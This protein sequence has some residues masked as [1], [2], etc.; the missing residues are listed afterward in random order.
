MRLN[1]Y[2]LEAINQI[3]PNSRADWKVMVDFVYGQNKDIVCKGGVMHAFWHDGKWNC[4]EYDLMTIID[5]DISKK[6]DDIKNTHPEAVVKGMYMNSNKTKVMKE[7]REYTKLSPQS[8]ILFNRRILFANDKMKKSDY[9]TTQLSYSPTPG[10]CPAFDELSNV[11]YSPEELEKILWFMGALLTNNMLKIQKFLYLYG[12]KGTGKGTMISIFK[13]LFED[14]WAP[15]DLGDLT[16][17][18]P[19][20]TGEIKEVPLLIDDDTDISNIKKDT[21]LLKLTAHE[22]IIINSKYKQTYSMRFEGLLITASNQRFKVRN[23]DSGITR[24]AVVAS[25]SNEKIHYKRYN[26]LMELIKYELPQIAQ[27]AMDVFTSN[28]PAYYEEYVDYEMIEATDYFY[29]F[30]RE[31]A[32]GLGDPCTLKKASELYKVYVDDMGYESTGYKRKVK[33]ELKRYYTNFHDAKKVGGQVLKNIFEGFKW[34]IVFPEKEGNVKREVTEEELLKKHDIYDQDSIFD[35]TAA[36]YPAQEATKEETPKYKWENVTT[37]LSQINTRELHYVRVPQN[38][39]VIDF[40][41]KVDNEK[42]LLKNLKA[43]SKYPPTYTELS[44]SGKGIH[45]HYIYEGDETKLAD[46]IDDN[47]EIKVY[48]GKSSLRRKLTKC[49]GLSIAHISSGLPLKE[50][51]ADV[52]KDIEILQLNEK[53]MRALVKGNLERKYHKNTKPSIDFIVKTFDD[54]LKKGVQYDLRD[55]RQDVLNFAMSSSNQ[56]QACLKLV[57]QIVFSTIE[58]EDSVL[59]QKTTKVIPNE[60]LYFY[61]LEVYPNLFICCYKRYGVDK[62]ERLINPKPEELEPIIGRPLVGYNNRRYDNH[63]MYGASIGEDNLSLYRQS[64]RI[65]NKDGGNGFYGGA[66]ELSYTDIYDYCNAANKKSLKKWEL[67]LGIKHDE[68][69]FPW[70]QPVPEEY[71]ERVA[72]YCANDVMATEA[73]FDATQSDYRTRQISS[74]LSGLSMNATTNQHTTKIIFGGDKNPEKELVYTDLGEIFPG[75][76][77]EFGKSTYRG[78][79]PGEGGYVYAEPGVYL[80]VRIY[81][82]TSQHPHSLI[83]LNALG[84]YTKVFEDLVNARV[85]I[86]HKQFE[87]AAKLF[88]GKLKPFLVD[89][90]TASDLANGL[91]TAI[92]SV[93]GL[94]SAK[95]PN[96]FKHP[97]NND[98]IVAKRGA[99]FMIDLKHAIMDMGYTV[100]HIKTDSIKIPNFPSGKEGED[101]DKFIMSFAE[102]YKYKFEHEATYDKLALVNKS[103]YICHDPNPRKGDPEWS[104]TGAQ[105]KEPYVFKTLFSKEEIEKEDFFLAKEVKDAAIY[106]GDRFVGKFA[107]VYASKSGEEMFRVVDDKKSYLNGTKG[108]LWKHSTLYSDPEDV[109]YTYY[110]SLIEE[111]KGAISEV[112]SLDL[113]LET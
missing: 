56:S 94:T 110:E 84:K 18:S 14:Y 89:E 25:P 35:V 19:F 106:L 32:L 6:V 113:M 69:E 12:G 73:V 30:V 92:N 64:Q 9:A 98:N 50:E 74:A 62:V 67:E 99:L 72:D 76:K 71:W 8:D 70:D 44:K 36:S 88:D 105:F 11:L 65:I 55:M 82:I 103:T 109:D 52:Y 43:I 111:A 13:M 28:G 3:S 49:N 27:K 102:K 80:N 26:E 29:S 96:A 79:D 10:E 45:L 15:I 1:F 24:R 63:I 31:N 54:A 95:F 101:L 51:R 46:V 77:Y 93:Y 34:E 97:K 90:T 48:K 108:H 47:I 57:N 4:S 42:S 91:K 40:D 41:L 5:N 61:D 37:T 58:P 86:K 59:Y 20:A 23:I 83:A 66:Y 81:D 112:G 104:A 38:H 2:R 7:F 17:D 16:G 33:N 107:E 75:Y 78:E 100:A 22:P 85:L 53:K 21:N 60:D 87:E 68:I 39:I